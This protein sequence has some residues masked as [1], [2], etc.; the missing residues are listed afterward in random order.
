MK[1]FDKY[2][3][4]LVGGAAGDALGYAVEFMLENQI[5]NKYGNNGITDYDLEYGLGRISDDTQMTMF[6]AV[7]L[8]NT[9]AVKENPKPKINWTFSENPI[10]SMTM[11]R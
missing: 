10:I 11:K 4:C 1:S 2:L 7:A 8:L 9:T 3:G 5:F 6:T